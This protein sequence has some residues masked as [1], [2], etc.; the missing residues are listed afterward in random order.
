[1]SKKILIIDDEL[2]MAEAMA[3]LLEEEGFV[4][5]AVCEG[6]A[7]LE[8]MEKDPPHLVILD[9]MMP[10]VKGTDVAKFMKDKQVL[11][12]VP[13]L[14]MSASK[15]PEPKDKSLWNKFI[16]KPFDIDQLL[17]EVR[18]LIEVVPATSQA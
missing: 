8:I 6:K 4:T 2:D 12:K 11:S 9:V 10:A 14:L 13:I 7:G 18:E 3:S 15:E 1:M 16:R 17:I 5:R